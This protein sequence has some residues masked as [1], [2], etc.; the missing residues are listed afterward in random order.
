MMK[1]KHKSSIVIHSFPCA[2]ETA[3]NHVKSS[4]LLFEEI[5][6]THTHTHKHIAVA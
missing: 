4:V 5:L 2:H 1:L 6:H 3:L